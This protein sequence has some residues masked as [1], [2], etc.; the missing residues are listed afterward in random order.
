MLSI[1]LPA[2]ID[3]RLERFAEEA[4]QTK[5]DYVREAIVEKVEEMEDLQVAEQVLERVR[6]GKD[7]VLSSE[8]IW[9]ELKG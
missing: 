7:S 2:E 5:S 1:R 8:Q 9:R 3:A 4:G 6:E